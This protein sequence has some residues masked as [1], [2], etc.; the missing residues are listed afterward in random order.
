LTSAL[1]SVPHAKAVRGYSMFGFSLVYVLFEDGT[2]LYWARSRVLEFLNFSRDRLPS[3]VNPKLGPDATGVGWVYEYTLE[4][5]LG[6]YDL[7]QLRS[8]Q[9]WYLKYELTSVP[10]VAE[11]ASVGGFVKQYQVEVDPHKLLIYNVTLSRVREAITRSNNDVGG[12]VIELSETEYMVRGLGYIRGLD[13]IR[14]IPLGVNQDGTPLLLRSVAGVK[15]GPELRRGLAEK[16]GEGEVVGGIVIMRSGE[17]A[18]EVIEDVKQKLKELQAGLP[19]GVTVKTA[20]DRS[21]LINRAVSN[22]REVLWQEML[23][24]ALVTILFLLHVRS[25]LVALLTLPLGVLAAFVIMR[26]F[27]INANIMSLGGIA[28]AIGEMVDAS[29]V[30]VENAHK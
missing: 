15:I 8:L 10:G 17:N 16:N 18:L 5:S 29:V 2:D 4:D 21:G 6:N 24:V 3:G 20:Y 30:M 28:V 25:A 27:G 11:V 19:E 9:D 12:G 14:N 23:F 22:L 13:D 26:Y 1:L 7:A